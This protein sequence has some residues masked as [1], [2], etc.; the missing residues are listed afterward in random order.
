MELHLAA[1]PLWCG[2]AGL[3]HKLRHN[4]RRSFFTPLLQL[5]LERMPDTRLRPASTPCIRSS[6]R[7]RQSRSLPVCAAAPFPCLLRRVAYPWNAVPAALQILSFNSHSASTPVSSQNR[8]MNASVR[9]GAA[10][11]SAYTTA[12]STSFSC[13][14]A[15]SRAFRAAQC[16]TSFVSHNATR[17]RVERSRHSSRSPLNSRSH[18]WIAFRPFPIAGLPIPI[19]FANGLSFRT[20]VTRTPFPMSSHCSRSPTRTP[21]LCRMSRGTVTCPL[22]VSLACLFMLWLQFLTLAH[23][24]LYLS[25]ELSNS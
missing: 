7:A 2:L 1:R 24:S 11:S 19:Y 4:F 13:P 16:K 15:A 8:S 5:A 6:R 21:S 20:A 23:S 9:P 10:I 18:F 14:Q 3:R 22:L 25:L 17:T 12:E